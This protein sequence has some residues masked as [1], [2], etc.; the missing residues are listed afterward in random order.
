VKMSRVKTAALLLTL[1]AVLSSNAA[2]DQSANPVA[3][4]A[5]SSILPAPG[6]YKIDPV[7]TFAYFGARHHVVGLVRGRFE[8]VTGTI[9]VAQ[10]RP[11]VVSTS[12][13]TR[14][15]SAP[16]IAIAMTTSA[17]P[18]SSMSGSFRR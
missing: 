8:N 12:R 1:S 15:V 2:T 17:A 5:S 9:I 10:D 6:I 11:A 14:G 18:P 16:R 4:N 13:S 3:K 7:H